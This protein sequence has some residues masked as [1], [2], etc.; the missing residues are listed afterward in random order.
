MPT[1]TRRPSLAL[2]QMANVTMH[3]LVETITD[4]RGT[5]WRDGNGL[6]I[7]NKCIMAFP[8]SF[9]AFPIFSDGSVW[10]LQAMRSNAAYLAG[11]GAVN[12]QGQPGCMWGG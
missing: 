11:S 12:G 3:E 8:P 10:K 1:A 7:G 4:P 5:G 2:A 9:G 6:E